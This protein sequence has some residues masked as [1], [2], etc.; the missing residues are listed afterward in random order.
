VKGIDGRVI[1]QMTRSA[2]AGLNSVVW[3]G[4]DSEGKPLPAGVYMVEVIARGSDGSFVRGITM[5]NLR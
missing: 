1:K 4:K 3:D 2:V 5:F